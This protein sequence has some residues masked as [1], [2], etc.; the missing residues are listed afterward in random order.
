MNI[1][2]ILPGLTEAKKLL[3]RKRVARMLP[4]LE[5]IPDGAM[6]EAKPV[7]QTIHSDSPVFNNEAGIAQNLVTRPNFASADFFD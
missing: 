2:L 6:F 3:L 4:L 5:T 1:H 7:S